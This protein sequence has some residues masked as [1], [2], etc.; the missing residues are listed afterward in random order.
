MIFVT[1]GNQEE[2][3]EL[4]NMEDQIAWNK[5]NLL[6]ESDVLED[7]FFDK[8]PIELRLDFS[9]VKVNRNDPRNNFSLIFDAVR[10]IL[11]NSTNPWHF[12]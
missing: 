7:E 8:E 1:S 9:I 10:V 5:A 3:E 4:T 2:D 11:K 6:T 12:L